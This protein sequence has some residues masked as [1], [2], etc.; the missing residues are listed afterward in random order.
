MRG[1]PVA[2]ILGIVQPVVFLV[3]AAE[4]AP[5]RSAQRG[6]ELVVGVA[7]TALW[8]STIWTAGAVLRGDL[9]QGTLARWSIAVC[10]PA[11]VFLGKCVGAVARSTVA[12]AFSTALTAAALRLP[13]QAHRPLVMLLGAVLALSSAIAL[14]MLL[15]CLFLVTRHA[16]AW[17]AAL[18]YPVFIVSGMIIPLDLV[19]PALR[20]VSA[21]ISLRWAAEFLGEAARGRMSWPALAALVGLTGVYFLVA[22]AAFRTLLRRARQQGTMEYE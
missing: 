7:L 5:V 16:N 8:G 2:L 17:S 22:L 12:V 20:G 3:I 6:S 1:S 11:V 21:A 10:P 15:S 9:Q 18:M 14:G 13:M 4:A 19:P